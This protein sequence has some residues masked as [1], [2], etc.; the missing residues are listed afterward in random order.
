MIHVWFCSMNF[1]KI[2]CISLTLL[3]SGQF[4]HWK[5]IKYVHPKK[6][7]LSKLSKSEQNFLPAHIFHPAGLLERLEYLSRLQKSDWVDTSLICKLT[8]TLYFKCEWPFQQYLTFPNLKILNTISTFTKLLYK[9]SLTLCPCEL[10][11]N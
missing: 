2:W 6:S 1:L 9:K 5:W 4:N 7:T 11:A 10:S 3:I 8:Q